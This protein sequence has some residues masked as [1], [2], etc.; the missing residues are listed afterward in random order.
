[1]KK[2]RVLF[3]C[4]GN[5]CRSPMAEGIFKHLVE[6]EGLSDQF[7]I[8]SAGTA[9]YHVGET[10]DER[11]IKTARR[12]GLTLDS[13]VRQLQARDFDR[14]DYIIGMDHSNYRNILSLVEAHD[15]RRNK[16]HMMLS[17]D[18]D[19]EAE[20]VEDPWYGG[21]QGFEDMY[22]ILTQANQAFLDHL[23][24]EHQLI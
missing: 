22:H 20:E 21:M 23:R 2:I 24:K 15:E 10:P 17:F 16:V 9:G 6:Q 1:M 3:V 11:S 12:Y 18:K 5:I 8:D 4:L 19:A 7:E 13:I 14:F